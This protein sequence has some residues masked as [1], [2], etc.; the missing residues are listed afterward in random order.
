MILER[1][2]FLQ[3]EHNKER[4]FLPVRDRKLRIMCHYTFSLNTH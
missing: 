1:R 4:H 2:R 3:M